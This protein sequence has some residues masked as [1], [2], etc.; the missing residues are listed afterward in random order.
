MED[1]PKEEIKVVFE[2][3]KI[4]VERIFSYGAESAADFW[5]DNDCDEWVTVV[6]GSA[7]LDFGEEKIALS[8][9]DNYYIEARVKHRVDF[10]S[11]DCEWLCVYLKK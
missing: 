3:D 2:N 8:A 11:R 7:V 9:G 6:K 4:K 10:T 1:C 5:Y